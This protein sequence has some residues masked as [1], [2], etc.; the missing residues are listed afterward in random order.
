MDGVVERQVRHQLLHPHVLAF[1]AF[2][3][4]GLVNLRPAKPSVLIMNA[5]KRY[6]GDG[7][8]NRM[9]AMHRVRWVE[10]DDVVLCLPHDMRLREYRLDNLERLKHMALRKAKRL[11]TSINYG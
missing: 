10:F 3:A 6:L 11:A 7:K 9:F 1:E 8:V 5:A 2:H 4:L